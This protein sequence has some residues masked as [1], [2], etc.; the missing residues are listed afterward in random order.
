MA[1]LALLDYL[2][3]TPQFAIVLDSSYHVVFVNQTIR[4]A[5]GGEKVSLESLIEAGLEDLEDWLKVV[6]RTGRNMGAYRSRM[7]F[8]TELNVEWSAVCLKGYAVMT[9]ITFSNDGYFDMALQGDTMSPAEST[10]LTK[11][12]VITSQSLYL[13]SLSS[14]SPVSIS[15]T[16]PSLNPVDDPKAQ[17][18]TRAVEPTPGMDYGASDE[19][20]LTIPDDNDDEGEHFSLSDSRSVASTGAADKG[21][22][23]HRSLVLALQGGGIMG[24]MLRNFDWEK[25]SVGLIASWPQSLI[26]TVSMMMGSRFPMALWWGNDLVMMYNDAYIPVAGAKHPKMFG[27]PGSVAWSDLWPDLEPVARSVMQ[28]STVYVE[29]DLLTMFRNGYDEE[30]YFTWA[31]TPVRREDG[32][33]AGYLNPCIDDTSRVITTRRLVALRDLGEKLGTTKSLPNV[34]TAL[35]ETLTD[36]PLDCPF[37]YIYTAENFENFDDHLTDDSRSEKFEANLCLRL[38]ESVGLPFDHPPFP[39]EI[40]VDSSLIQAKRA[41]LFNWPFKEVCEKRKPVVVD[42][43]GLELSMEGRSFNDAITK[44]IVYPITTAEDKEV[45]G[46]IIMG[47]NSRRVYD[48]EYATF[49]SLL[50]RQIGTYLV[51]VNAY[52]SEVKRAEE[53]L[54]IDR[55]KTSFFSSISH[56]LRTPLTLILSPLEDLIADTTTPLVDNHKHAVNLVYRNARRLLRLVNSILDFSRVE[57]GRMTTRLY[58]TD[59]GALTADLA[60]VFRS[61]IEKG[62][63]HFEVDCE[64]DG[65]KV[66]IDRDMWEKVVF[67]LIGNAF[68]FT[69]SGTITVSVHPSADKTAVVFSVSDTGAGI[70][71]HE[72]SRVFER[73]HRIE[74]QRGRSHEGTGIGLALT[75]ELVKLLGGTLEVE[76]EFARAALNSFSTFTVTLP[77][78]TTHHNPAFLQGK[79]VDPN[80]DVVAKRAW[81]YGS[82]MVDEARLWLSSDTE[83]SY[84]GLQPSDSASS[85]ENISLTSGSIPMT[86]KGCRILLADDNPDMQRYIKTVLSR[87]WN[88]TVVPDGRAALEQAMREPPDLI[89][90]DVMMPILDGLSLL[91]VLRSQPE[92]NF[93][94]IIL[95][96]ARAGEAARVDGLQAGADDYLVKP[97]NA[98]ELIARVHTHLEL[99]KLRVELEKR[100]RQRT[101]A[102]EESEYRYK[103]LAALSPVGIFR[104]NPEGKIVYT[105]E[106]WW[107]ITGHDRQGDPTAAGYETSMHVGDKDRVSDFL[108]NLLEKGQ[109]GT[110][111]YRW[112]SQT[113]G[114]ERWCICQIIV[115]RDENDEVQGFIGALMDVTERRKLEKERLDAL[116]LAEQ[117]QRRRAEEAE[118]VKKQQ[119]LFIDMTC[120]EL[121][122]PLNG[123][124]HNA[125][126]LHDS[127]TKMHKEVSSLHINA[128]TPPRQILP[129]ISPGIEDVNVSESVTKVI[130]RLGNEMMQDLEAIE[131]INLCALHQK[132]IADDVLQMSKIS[133]NLV[134][135]SHQNFDPDEEIQNILRMFET[136]LKRKDIESKFVIGEGYTQ[137]RVR[138]VKGDPTRLGQVVINLLAN[139]IRFT[140]KSS[141]KII[142]IK[143]DAEPVKAADK[144]NLPVMART[145]SPLPSLKD[146]HPTTIFDFQAEPINLSEDELKDS[147]QIYLRV[148]IQDTG[149]GMTADEQ[150]QLFR[151]FTQANPKTYSEFGG[152]GLGLFIS[153]HLIELQGGEIHV[154]ST[155]NVGTTFHFYIVCE[156]GISPSASPTEVQRHVITTGVT[157]NLNIKEIVDRN[158][159][160][161]DIL[162]HGRRPA[163]QSRE[164]SSG[165]AFSNATPTGDEDKIQLLVVEDNLVNQKILTRQIRTMG[166]RADVANNGV[167]ALSRLK[168]EV[169]SPFDIILM[170]IEMPLMDGI[171]ATIAIRNL[172]QEGKLLP[173]KEAQPRIPIIAVTG[174]ARK[175][176]LENALDAGMDDCI[177]KPYTKMELSEKLDKFLR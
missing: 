173:R 32:S 64:E 82:A 40:T 119:E 91:K 10:T 128:M 5:T 92:T 69:L 83:S 118:A 124:Y 80:D 140:E 172:E 3:L 109:S 103:I 2:E 34:C 35:A 36:C 41:D 138:F 143:I 31:W 67:N 146:P 106:K 156:L 162:K 38:Q 52:Q 27:K 127:L 17:T 165:S 24:S 120:H 54:A 74:G 87:W 141:R 163:L 133:M 47:L 53:L 145:V 72:L 139:A 100:V 130:E 152:N 126:I 137:A 77:Y 20:A 116:A 39:K 62:G 73:F 144:L 50:V 79:E 59:L 11:N 93:I 63:V 51:T 21:W 9:G 22:R 99:G 6:Y 102:F 169:T 149:V 4:N 157:D 171:Q 8:F 96:S 97:F 33:V 19:R 90:T 177:V 28:G 95:L 168:A 161:K 75:M 131:T 123:I 48:G 88:V 110:I 134:V 105:N 158:E 60:S 45:S 129:G 150:T 18:S 85:A 49:C 112:V 78:G 81:T 111:E 44:A 76:S 132:K 113:D 84:R 108:N 121:R 71:S 61:A 155:K 164:T 56:E 37:A 12:T 16:S 166:H 43:T 98:K 159:T 42:I 25:T 135:L 174:N 46:V 13:N 15:E 154:E 68:K 167:E 175:E 1:T 170:D 23:R 148:S 14:T 153:K 107:E 58:E 55:A 117:Q 101:K 115:N 142:T 94:P 151:R 30:T 89:V 125:D 160:R 29:S 176:Q 122:N 57:A 147:E 86:S 104:L 66:W 136:E 7:K 70:P 65:R 26:S 114:S